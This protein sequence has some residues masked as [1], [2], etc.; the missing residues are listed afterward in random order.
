ML[1]ISC[2]A[3]SPISVPAS[4]PSIPHI[5]SA[6]CGVNSSST[7]A[8]MSPTTPSTTPVASASG[9]PTVLTASAIG[10]TRAAGTV[11]ST[12]R[13]SMLER[14]VLAVPEPMLASSR[15]ASSCRSLYWLTWFLSGSGGDGHCDDGVAVDDEGDLAVRQHGGPGEGGAVGDLGRQRPR[16]ELVLADQAGDREREAL[17]AAA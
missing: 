14:A 5:S 12:L 9:S 10:S 3:E 11:M 13:P 4:T 16:D 7:E 1:P 15:R 6:S 8:P 17:V 2:R